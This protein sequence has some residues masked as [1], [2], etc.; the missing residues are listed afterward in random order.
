MR[1][2]PPPE[3]QAMPAIAPEPAANGEPAPVSE[4]QRPLNVLI[5][6]ETANGKSTLIRQLSVYAGNAHPEIK[7]GYGTWR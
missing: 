7:I 6:G 1:V 4:L 3:Y 2:T 5:L